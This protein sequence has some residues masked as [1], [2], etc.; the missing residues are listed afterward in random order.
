MGQHKLTKA[1]KSMLNKNK[2]VCNLLKTWAESAPSMFPKVDSWIEKVEATTDLQEHITA[3][4]ISILIHKMGVMETQF[5]KDRPRCPEPSVYSK[6][7]KIFLLCFS[8]GQI[9]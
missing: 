8:K 4:I 1:W 6:K 3:E 7:P 2:E 9:N 5:R